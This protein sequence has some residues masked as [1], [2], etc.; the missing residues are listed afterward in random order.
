MKALS[1]WQ[2]WGTLMELE[3]KRNETR[4]WGTSYRGPLAIHAAKKWNGDLSKLCWREPF[5][6]A[7]RD[8]LPLP[9]GHILCVV[10]LFDCVQINAG[11]APP[12]DSDERA[13]GDYT[14]GRFMW[15]T[16]NCV[17][18]AKP[19]PFCGAQGFFEVPDSLFPL[20]LPA[21]VA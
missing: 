18:L 19:I 8:H 9:L 16:R 15:R 14:P 2:P 17:R 6:A 21:V 5:W 11:N 7:L 20:D 3:A 13:F 10:D 1:L 12:P 4:S